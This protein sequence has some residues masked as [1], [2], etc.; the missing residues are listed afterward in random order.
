MYDFL[1]SKRRDSPDKQGIVGALYYDK[2]D[3]SSSK[4]CDIL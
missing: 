2:R 3:L 4:K 1:P